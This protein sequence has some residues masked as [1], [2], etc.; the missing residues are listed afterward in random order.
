MKGVSEHIKS[1]TFIK[2]GNKPI[3]EVYK[4]GKQL[5]KGNFGTV[6][7]ATHIDL[8]EKRAIK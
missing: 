2:A 1:Q 8:G 6:W 3:H 4:F 7:I 5:G